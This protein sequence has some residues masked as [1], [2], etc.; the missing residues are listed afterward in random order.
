VVCHI[1]F[2]RRDFEIRSGKK[3]EAEAYLA[4]AVLD[5]CFEFVD[6]F[7][8]HFWAFVDF[9]AGFLPVCAAS[10]VAGLLPYVLVDYVVD[11]LPVCVSYFEV[12]LFQNS[13]EPF[14]T[15]QENSPP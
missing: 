13:V 15:T 6:E 10:S 1:K 14:P 5:E 11:L 4:Y 3:E 2:S 12:G 7:L 9:S 8:L